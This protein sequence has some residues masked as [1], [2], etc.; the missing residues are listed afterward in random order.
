MN[1]NELKHY[2]VLGMKWG[3][4]RYQKKNGTLT[5]LGKKHQENLERIE[6]ASDARS[7][8]NW[9]GKRYIK[10]GTPE[11]E[12]MS[13]AEDKNI[14][15]TKLEYEAEKKRYQEAKRKANIDAANY[16]YSQQ[17]KKANEAV[18]TMSM[19]KALGQSMMLGSFGALK[20][21][22]AKARGASGGK[23]VVE[24]VL[25]N[26]GNNFLYGALSAAQYLDNRWARK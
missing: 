26:W 11:Y 25:Y 19:G 8:K 17:S 3:I 16:L 6:R 18:A 13:K 10:R 15:R 20:Y 1:N 4:R 21:N 24:G 12:K 9:G 5:A 14:E 23:A 22:E 7:D 2:G